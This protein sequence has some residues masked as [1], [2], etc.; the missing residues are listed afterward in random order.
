M[1]WLSKKKSALDRRMEKIQ[2]EDERIRQDIRSLHK[3]IKR[4][5]PLPR[6]S[7]AGADSDDQNVG[8]ETRRGRSPNLQRSAAEAIE[9]TGNTVAY[10]TPQ[11]SAVTRSRHR[12]EDDNRFARYFAT[13]SL[14]GGQPLKQEKS[15]QRNKAIFM[16]L[17]V[18][19][20]AFIVFKLIFF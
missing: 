12:Q 3:A 15:I 16:I 19:M 6:A 2:R 8:S 11:N 5:K 10:R 18:S 4:S 20:L 1:S 17:F 7:S 9:E 13:G 14:M